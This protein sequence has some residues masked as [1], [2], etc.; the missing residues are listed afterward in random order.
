M[1]ILANSGQFVHLAL[2]HY[3]GVLPTSDIRV[4]LTHPVNDLDNPIY[5]NYLPAVGILAAGPAI[6]DLSVEVNQPGGAGAPSGWQPAPDRSVQ[7]VSDT[8]I[9]VSY[10]G[11]NGI[12]RLWADDSFDT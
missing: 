9:S 8:E 11:G 1:S 3:G 5:G 10:W 2:T 6:I 7:Q 4:T 12:F